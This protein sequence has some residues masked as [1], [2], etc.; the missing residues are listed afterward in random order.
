MKFEPGG[1]RTVDKL[2]G[3]RFYAAGGHLELSLLAPSD[4]ESKFAVIGELILEYLGEFQ[5]F[6][7]HA[8]H[9]KPEPIRNALRWPKP[10]VGFGDVESAEEG[11]AAVSYG[12]ST[13]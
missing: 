9:H 11:L 1:E 6:H 12:G 5:R 13:R 7:A 3:V 2:V 4:S 10:R 8:H